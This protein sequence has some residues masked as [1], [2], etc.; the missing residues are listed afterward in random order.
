MDTLAIDNKSLRK[1]KAITRL[2]RSSTSESKKLEATT[3]FN[4][5]QI[6][7]KSEG[8]IVL[9]HGPPGVGKTYTAECVAEASGMEIYLII[10]V[11]T[12]TTCRSTTSAPHLH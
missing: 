5:D 7:G 3:V 2:N 11:Q 10:I 6:K 4:A 9:L 1:I 8:R 12:L